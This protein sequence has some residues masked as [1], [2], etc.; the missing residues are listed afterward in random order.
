MTSRSA[1][2]RH[3][4]RRIL[5]T[6]PSHCRLSICS[7]W[8]DE[9]VPPRSW[10]VHDRIPRRQPVLFSGEG[11]AGKSL[12]ELQ[13]AAAHVLGRDWIGFMPVHG[14]VIYFGAEDEQDEIHRRLAD[15]AAYY[16]VKFRD[17]IDGGLHLVFV[18]RPRCSVGLC[19]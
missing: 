17:L 13:R 10:A 4:A 16:R 11:A 2:T 14:P 18:R 7:T 8:D 9:P 5:M 19:G 12:L 3:G 15:I 1:V 6:S